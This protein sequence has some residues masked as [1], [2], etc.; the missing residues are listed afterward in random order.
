MGGE[1]WGEKGGVEKGGVGRL[2][3]GNALETR[4]GSLRIFANF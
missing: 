1:G 2:G 4:T 3:P